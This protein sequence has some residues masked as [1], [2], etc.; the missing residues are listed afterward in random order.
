M[1]EAS[2]RFYYVNSCDL[3]LNI[4]IKIGT[5]EG[6]R[7][8]PSYRE[9]LED[10][11]LRFSGLY[12]DTCSDLYVTCQ[13]FADGK[14]LTL[15]TRTCYKAFTTRWNWNEWLTLPVK[16]SDLPRNAQAAFTIWDV[17]SPTEAKPVGGTTVALFGKHG[18]YRQGMHD[19][20]VWP[21]EVADGGTNSSTPGKLGGDDM[22]ARLAKLTKKHHKGKM[23]KVDWLDRLTFR[24]LEMI[25]E[26][27][28]RESNFMFLMIEFARIHYNN[29][30]F[31]IVYYEK[32]AEEVV[33]IR[34]HADIVT[35]PDPEMLMENLVE[36][37]HHTLV[38]SERSGLSDRD[39]KPNAH[40]RDQLS[41]IIKFGPNKVL[42]SEEA[43][44]IW[45]FRFYLTNQKSALTKFLKSVKWDVFHEES[46]ALELMRKWQPIDVADALELLSPQFKNPDVRR[47]AVSRLKQA[48]DEELMLYLLQLVQALKY[49]NFQEIKAG[50]ESQ[51]KK[52]TESV[53][54][55]GEK[56][57]KNLPHPLAETP[58]SPQPPT[59]AVYGSL[60]SS[61]S[62]KEEEEEDEECDLA[63]FLIQRSCKNY[64]L[65]NYFYWY[66][67]VEKD[68]QNSIS[69]DSQIKEMYNTVMQR[70]GQHLMK[71]IPD[72]LKKHSQLKRQ[73]VLINKLVEVMRQV[74]KESGN[75]KKKIERLQAL[76]AST[77]FSK[78]ML[79][80]FDPI[81]LPIQPEIKI[82]G[83]IP[84]KASI[85]KSALL[86]C[87][88]VFRTTENKDYTV[89]A[90]TGDDLRQDQLILQI[91]SLMDKLLQQENLDLK[92][93]PYNVLATSCKTGFVQF[94]ESTAVADV[95]SNEG[96]IQN[97][98]RKHSPKENA[99]YNI[100]PDVMDTYVKS[101][102]GYCV[103][104]YL[105]GVGDRHL[106]NLL[107]TTK[108]NLFHVDFGYILGR[109]PKPFPPPMKLS[110][111]MLEGMG[112]VNSE[113]FQDFVTLCYTSFL[114]LRRH[115]NLILNLFSLMVDA[116]VPD[117]ALEP[118][119]TVKKL[120]D[121][122]RLDLTDEEAV[123]YMKNLIDVSA[124]AMFAAW[125][126]QIHKLAQYWKK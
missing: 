105:L 44:L 24:E 99:A 55:Q 106:D 14:A 54:S 60:P 23:Q 33:T 93:T 65:A 75:R 49:E 39:L 113:Q 116:N 53:S 42:T 121:K 67:M 126:E 96:S 88:L 111:E 50:L 51:S 4:Q 17:Y 36:A 43:D 37:K 45:R 95:L 81:P 100:S 71:G 87:R 48:N 58:D 115:A 19:L 1:D 84:E 120:Q 40:T 97:F 123:Q 13:I 26:K 28:K 27:E 11:Q 9:L 122:F 3:D 18:T 74:A 104:T 118:D 64:T 30:D 73:N 114:H 80:N 82:N 63:T 125:V 85:F 110:K 119:K 76:L 2:D 47:Y 101:S 90:K 89:I 108:G 78:Q 103:I 68:D 92:L 59:V 91:I 107:L 35:V 41:H 94:I 38:R 77:E 112:G 12:E 56:E 21:D 98:F 8:K 57:S 29:I 70:F 72:Y 69:K 31:S 61:S 117:I 79:S 52:R 7:Q 20:K 5:L 66:L 16:Y 124:G 46:Q 6:K 83:L 34:H 102:A 62:E 32:D 22:M 15:P 10:P 109:D 86:P 25:N